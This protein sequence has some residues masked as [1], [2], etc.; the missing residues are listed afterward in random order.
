[1]REKV[2]HLDRPPSFTSQSRG[3][4][5]ELLFP[6][7]GG[8]MT[9]WVG[10]VFT[11]PALIRDGNYRPGVVMWA[12]L[13]SDLIVAV[14]PYDPR[15]PAPFV[16]T[17]LGALEKLP[18]GSSRPSRIRVPW[19][20]LAGEVRKA[21]GT[22][23]AV[24]TAPVPELDEIFAEFSESMDSSGPEPS[25][26]LGGEIS[27]AVIERLFSAAA[28]Y[29]RVAPWRWMGD[30]Q[31]VRADIPQVGIEGG[32]LSVIGAAGESF[33]LLLFQSI[34]VYREFAA[35]S[36]EVIGDDA[37]AEGDD[38]GALWMLSL[39][40]DRRKDL[41]PAMLDEIKQHRWPVAGSKAY[42]VIF[43]MSGVGRPRPVDE[44]E[45][46]VMTAVT[47]AFVSFFEHHGGA[48]R[49]GGVEPVTE[50]LRG[51]D[52]IT[53]TL[54]TP[55]AAGG[56]T[57]H[58][59]DVALVHDIWDFATERFG[60]HWFG[61]AGEDLEGDDVSLP[62]LVPWLVWT[63][64]VRGRRVA[65]VYI[66]EE[67]SLL[68]QEEVEW[69]DEQRK[70]WLSIW[71][72]TAVQPGE[73]I[74]LRDLLTGETRRVTEVLASQSLR[75][76]DAIL[77]RVAGVGT[78]CLLAGMFGRSLPPIDAAEFV[79]EVRARLRTA[80]RPVTV[81]RLQDP[82]TGRFMIDLWQDIVD[83]MDEAMSRPPRLQN[84][85][86]DDL[87]L[88]TDTFQFDAKDWKEIER[89]LGELDGAESRRAGKVWEVVI[90]RGDDTVT[91]AL[92]VEQGKLRIETNSLERA[93]A[94]RDQ[95]LKACGGMLRGEKRKTSVPA[96]VT[97]RAA[98]RGAR[99][100]PTADEQEVVRAAKTAYYR[101]WLDEP[102]PFLEGKTPRAAARSAKWRERLEVLLRDIENREAK[103]PEPERVD[104]GWLRR[105]LGLE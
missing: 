10:G 94:L 59:I 4:S 100:E 42:P 55:L 87:V 27:P 85:D 57:I 40:F 77:A 101:G 104:V 8:R 68:S 3:M 2:E 88:V 79:K 31:L 46:T 7:F 81:E 56:G 47:S 98:A 9:E 84:G 66:E 43:A 75:V 53:V 49:S 91:G 97:P 102:I 24:V 76:R 29:Y 16:E 15:L 74:D 67:G 36:P 11:L 17:L 64:V 60:P 26:L 23:I 28:S 32:C 69:I 21:V 78:T 71:E 6:D 39:S 105:E 30:T 1:M 63:A 51:E 44:R 93:A 48:L 92:E 80:K 58:E 33:G 25:Y 96:E 34:D 18:Q 38:G 19:K 95:V 14:A 73:A 61:R 50:T 89:R 70:A 52:G 65:D 62:L 12:E 13:P 22:G 45:V 5:S 72:V 20:D 35:M 82:K 99:R 86:G 41:S 37:P 103:L 90:V 54:S 83:D